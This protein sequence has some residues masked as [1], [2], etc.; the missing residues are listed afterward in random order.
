M[1]VMRLTLRAEP[2][3]NAHSVESQSREE[4]QLR[5]AFCEPSGFSKEPTDFTY[6]Y[7][8]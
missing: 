4:A 5:C 8:R 3:R 7:G 2:Q 1:N 6:I